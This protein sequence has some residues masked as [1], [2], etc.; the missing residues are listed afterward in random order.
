MS[1]PTCRAFRFAG[2][3]NRPCR[4][5]RRGAVSAAGAWLLFADGSGGHLRWHRSR[6]FQSGRQER[7]AGGGCDVSR[8]RLG[9]APAAGGSCAV[10]GAMLLRRG[11]P[12]FRSWPEGL[13][14]VGGFVAVLVSTCVLTRLH[15]ADDGGLPAGPGGAVGASIVAVGLPVLNWVGLTLCAVADCRCWWVRRRRCATRGCMSSSRSGAALRRSRGGWL[16]WRW[17]RIEEVDWW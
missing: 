3:G 2:P 9:R 10:C 12:D 6:R 8:L 14:R 11:L 13:I 7:S 4:V 1:R 15:A 16:R 17:L 5:C